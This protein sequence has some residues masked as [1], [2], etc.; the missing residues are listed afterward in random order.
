MMSSMATSAMPERT[1]IYR[2]EF[3]GITYRIPALVYIESEKIFLVFAE[4]HRIVK[5]KDATDLVMKRGL[6]KN[7]YVE[8]EGMQPLHHVAMKDCRTKTPCPVYEESSQM[9]FLFFTCI[10]NRISESQQKCRGNSTQLYYVYSKDY[11]I[12]WS[13]PIDLTNM[14]T[15]AFPKLATFAVGPGHGIQIQS[16]K[17]ILPAYAQV[18]KLMCLCIFPC[19]IQSTSFYVYSEDRGKTWHV[20]KGIQKFETSECQLA[21]IV[22]KSGENIIYCNARTTGK[23]RV[24]ALCQVVGAEFHHVQRSK[25]LKETNTGCHGSV[26]SF[27]GK[28]KSHQEPKCGLLYSHPTT[29]NQQ[30]LGVWCNMSPERSKGWSRPHIIYQGPSGY[31][32]LVH[33]KEADIFAIVFECGTQMEYEEIAFCFFTLK[34]V[35]E[36]TKKK[37]GIFAKF[38]K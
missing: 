30:D 28:E 12:T 36:N 17:L 15:K 23:S 32:D 21:E 8:W 18:A 20:S 26:I 1:K 6:Y 34:D 16:G 2:A 37:K 33:C 19:Y 13:L 25:K 31:S 7:G 4:R 10:P 3:D 29:K 27:F 35:L 9:L 11:G 38:R 14:I 5:D 22:S 24:E